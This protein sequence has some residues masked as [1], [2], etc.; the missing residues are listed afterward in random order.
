M[1]IMATNHR[2]AFNKLLKIGCPVFNR[3]EG[4]F[5]IHPCNAVND[6]FWANYDEP[7]VGQFGVSKKITDVLEEHGLFAEW[8]NPEYLSVYEA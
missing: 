5:E 8:V 2:R 3:G 6:E 4:N 7:S 1:T